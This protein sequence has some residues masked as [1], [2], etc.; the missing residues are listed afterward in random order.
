MNDRYVS[1]L[2]ER[3]ASREMQYIF[4]PDKKFKTWRKLWIALAETEKELGLP[5]TDE[6]IQELKAHAEEINYDVARERERQVRHDVMSHVYAYGVQCPKAKGIIH[7]GATSCYVGDNTDMIIMAEAL[8]L[9]RKKLLN[10]MAELAAFARRYKDQPTLAFTHFQPAQPTT[11][12]KR[13]T[14]WLMELKLDLDD[15]DY[16]LGTMKL[17]G[18]KGTTGTQASFLEL[19]DGDHEKCRRAD[20]MIAEKMGFD[21]CFPVSGQTYSRKIDSRVL[22]VLAGIAQST[23]KFSNDIRLLQHLKEVEEPFE[24]D[25]IGSSAMAYKRNPM[26]SER[27]ASLSNYVMAD[28]MNPMLVA[29]TQWFE[30]T[31]DDS[32]NKR[33]SVPEGFLAVDGILDLY[34]NVVDGLVVYPKVIEKHMMAELPFMATENIMMDAVKAGGDRQELHER[35]RTLSMEAGRNV[36]AEG[37]ENDLLER[38]AADPA[39]NLSLEELKKTMDPKRYVGRAPQQVE[40]FLGEVIDPILEVNKGELG[41]KAEIKV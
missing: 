8:R 35:I 37:G 19:F 31:L 36:K 26:R 20:Q 4:S 40:E 21:G 30:R 6:Q 41:L 22:S 16:V 24:K 33:L 13:A 27:I 17:L 32:A 15:V 25:Q 5:I 2:S 39:F 3:Y 18:S 11:V 7:L 1:P 14:L 28:V 34:L 23:H 10:V 9:V 29:S 12:G 38:I